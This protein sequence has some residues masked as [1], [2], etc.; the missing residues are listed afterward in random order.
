MKKSEFKR[1]K[2]MRREGYSEA[3]IKS[4]LGILTSELGKYQDKMFTVTGGEIIDNHDGTI[5]LIP[6]VQKK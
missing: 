2:K 1:R 4:P 6:E 3:F 5:T